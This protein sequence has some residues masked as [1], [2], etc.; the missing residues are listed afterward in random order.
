MTTLPSNDRWRALSSALDELLD[1]APERRIDWINNAASLRDEDRSTLRTMLNADGSFAASTA[2]GDETLAKRPFDG[3]FSAPAAQKLGN[4][5]L[6][7]KLADGGM[8]SVWLAESSDERA[9]FVAADATRA[10]YAI[11]L[12]H[13]GLVAG[14]LERFRQEGEILASLSHP[15][16]ASLVEMGVENDAPFLVLTYVRGQPITDY[17]QANR[18]TLKQRLHLFAQVL[19]AVQYAH[20]R[21][22]LHRD[23]KP[24]NIFVTEAGEARLLDFGV[25][26]LIAEGELADR[27][28]DMTLMY[29]RAMTPLYASP[30]QLRGEPLTIAS[31][32]YSLGLVLYELLTDKRVRN[33]DVGGAT[34]LLA[35]A[36]SSDPPKASD[37]HAHSD[38]SS[39][40]VNSAELEGDID[41]IV[42]K[43]LALDPGERYLT[44]DAFADDIRRFLDHEPVRAQ[45]PTVRYRMGRFLRRYRIAAS[46]VGFLS[47]AIVVVAAVA[48]WQASVANEERKWAENQSKRRGQATDFVVGLIS[49]YRSPEQPITTLGLLESGLDRIPTAF[50][51]DWV[52][53]SL[54]ANTLSWRI[55]E[56][57]ALD[58]A[59]RGLEAS[60]DFAKKSGDIATI[61]DATSSLADYSGKRNQ[62]D[63]AYRL[64]AEARSRVGEIQ[65]RR[66]RDVV[67]SNILFDS[68]SIAVQFGDARTAL[69]TARE[70]VEARTRQPDPQ[71][72]TNSAAWGR[73]AAAQTIAMDFDG[74]LASRDEAIKIVEQ[75]GARAS[76]NHQS[77]QWAR[78]ET[79]L[80]SGDAS[81]AVSLIQA[82]AAAEESTLATLTTTLLARA[83]RAFANYGDIDL[84]QRLLNVADRRTGRS[85]TDEA[86]LNVARF[87]V[88][89]ARNDAD[90]VVR[91]E[92]SAVDAFE[93]LYSQN[94]AMLAGRHWCKAM[95]AY[96][97]N[98]LVRAND[99]IDRGLAMI[100]GHIDAPSIF[101]A[102]LALLRGRAMLALRRT[103]VAIQAAESARAY[104]LEHHRYAHERV[105]DA[106]EVSVL[107]AEIAQARG[108]LA[109]ENANA[110]QAQQRSGQFLFKSHPLALRVALVVSSSRTP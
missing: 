91:T 67:T 22:I 85:R 62:R 71:A 32:V 46:V 61:V 102:K 21:L 2:L 52:A 80:R 42:G 9:D 103:D 25:A 79:I 97:A 8:S 101:F 89:I 3:Q 49:Q 63:R 44:V 11:K 10:Q 18:L 94:G 36:L 81:L 82:L 53:A 14:N 92:K 99:E 77:A 76:V 73:L 26:K 48:V 96:F 109:S 55:Y 50:K 83:V 15:N 106:I 88:C 95:A 75:S 56:L 30:E 47:L 78:L 107:Q 66:K 6:I 34:A 68:S 58:H 54:M 24:S 13:R 87:E 7:R 23:L 57:G 98:D 40:A 45:P 104:L 86:L 4:Y 12:P 28:G 84:A 43:A 59:E 100:A 110:A 31:D 1:L 60:L 41:A 108:V 90:C 19:S 70:L 27:S 69:A 38:A 39:T 65:D 37:A 16:I 5:V 29:G 105:T 74:A 17:A 20:S 35:K 72:I 64:L 51:D 33:D 93:Q